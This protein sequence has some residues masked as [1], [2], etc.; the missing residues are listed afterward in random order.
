MSFRP[1]DPQAPLGHELHP[2]HQSDFS[3]ILGGPDYTPPG[4][5][6]WAKTVGGT[7]FHDRM[8]D[9]CNGAQRRDALWYVDEALKR[10]QRVA[11]GKY[12]PESLALLVE[13]YCVAVDN[14]FRPRR[15]DGWV[16]EIGFRYQDPETGYWYE[17]TIDLLNLRVEDQRIKTASLIDYKTGDALPDLRTGPQHHEYSLAVKYGVLDHVPYLEGTRLLDWSKLT[18]LPLIPRK[19][20]KEFRFLHLPALINRGSWFA[21]GLGSNGEPMTEADSLATMR[22][23][24]RRLLDQQPT[25]LAVSVSAP[26]EPQPTIEKMQTTN[27]FKKATKSA[28]KLR[29]ALVGPSGSGKTY[30]ALKIATALGKRVAVMDTE[31]GSASKYASEFDFDVLEP[32]SFAPQ[33]YINSIEAAAN[34]GY[35]VI[36]LDSLS[37]AWMGRDG[38]L[39]Q[40][41]KA[42]AAAKNGDNR[43]TAWRNVTPQHNALIESIIRAGLHVVATMRVK[44][45]YVM[46]DYTDS[47]GNKKQKPVKVGLGA[48]QRDGLE[49]EFDVV[50]DLDIDH[51]LTISKT[52]CPALDGMQIHKPGQEVASKL[53]AWL[54]DGGEPKQQAPKPEAQQQYTFGEPR[55]AGYATDAQ[56]K[57]IKANCDA[58][59]INARKVLVTA[60]T[61]GAPQQIVSVA[62]VSD[63]V[64]TQLVMKLDGLLKSTETPRPDREKT[65]AEILDEQIRQIIGAEIRTNNAKALRELMTGGSLTP[66]DVCET[67][68][69]E[70]GPDR[71]FNN[72]VEPVQGELLAAL[73]RQANAKA[74]RQLVAT[75]AANGNGNG[76]GQH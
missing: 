67:M 76:N 66:D 26:A 45:D 73:K 50:A 52:R 38:A 57:R 31:H 74:E 3:P 14:V 75:G 27:P 1:P 15:E 44:T 4:G 21:L 72:L 39:D 56:L 29:L 64:A 22:A 36:V 69:A 70:V 43:F 42:A 19:W 8:R 63:K 34:A 60:I 25:R 9:V 23:L 28:A 68:A 65:A 49:Y 41:D 61:L 54:S 5:G 59:G 46:E 17:G 10:E 48:I 47:R 20:P 40:V 32:E 2:I 55:G 11:W 6:V 30:T 7:A 37:H 58:L 53:L 33:Q 35:D 51:N 16:A 62:D 24:T 12:S 18:A 71:Q 13:G